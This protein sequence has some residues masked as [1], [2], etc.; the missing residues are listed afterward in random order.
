MWPSLEITL[1]T[2]RTR[3]LREFH[4]HASLTLRLPC[5]MWR[6]G[7][8]IFPVWSSLCSPCGRLVFGRLMLHRFFKLRDGVR[9]ISSTHAPQVRDESFELCRLA[10]KSLKRF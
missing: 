2:M 6:I 5:E 3:N 4:V 10:E 9:T 1:W 7:D 8:D